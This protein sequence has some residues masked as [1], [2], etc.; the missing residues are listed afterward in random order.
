MR[1]GGDLLRRWRTTPRSSKRGLPVALENAW[2]DSVGESIAAHSR[3]IGLNSRGILTVAVAD[4]IWSQ[5][6]TARAEELVEKL[7]ATV[8]GSEIRGLKT[9]V[10]DQVFSGA[11]DEPSAPPPPPPSEADRAAA[12]R[13]AGG[14]SDPAV[15]DAVE[16][17][18]A[19]DL[20][21][22]N[23]KDK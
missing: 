10:A 19:A 6:V 3:P 13:L 4:A 7:A 2:S 12:Q 17:A 11:Q 23:A 8:A 14:I 21:R 16:R 22:R 15:R 18:A 5:E 1:P 20:S 9:R